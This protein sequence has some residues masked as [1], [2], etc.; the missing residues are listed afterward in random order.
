[1]YILHA[2]DPAASTFVLKIALA[3]SPAG[4]YAHLNLA[5]EYGLLTHLH[6]NRATYPL[7]IP[8]PT[9]LALSAA[10]SSL[11]AYPYLLLS[12]PPGVLV[13][14]NLAPAQHA[15][16]D[17]RRGAFYAALHAVDNDYYG[18]HDTEEMERLLSWQDAFLLMLE[19]ALEEAFPAATTDA[20]AAADAAR[21]AAVRA[22][23]VRALG[24]F[25]FE[26]VEWPHLAACVPDASADVL[27]ASAPDDPAGALEIACALPL[28]LS[29]ARWGDPLLERA[30]RGPPA[31]SAAFHAGYTGAD[32]APVPRARERAKALWYRVLDAAVVLAYTRAAGAE[33]A[34][35]MRE[36]ELARGEI[37]ECVARLRE[38][39][40]Y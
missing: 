36:A 32:E 40:V 20:N 30:L 3:A 18:R 34:D 22:L 39:P 4:S 6:A 21:A 23:L 13:P 29:C 35:G 19:E 5:A 28:G 10:P 38:I 31:P 15:A 11:L 8:I 9:P 27:L 1:V 12:R 26:D 37:D 17:L 24:A 33:S 16:L 14:P 2:R 7:P 25:V